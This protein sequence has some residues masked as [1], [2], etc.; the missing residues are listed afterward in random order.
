MAWE[1]SKNAD[2]AIDFIIM[3]NVNDVPDDC[4]L[5]LGIGVH[6]DMQTATTSKN[7]RNA[8]FLG[9]KVVG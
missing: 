7:L 3:D 8:Q 6:I 1:D 5:E 9:K 2:R 4:A